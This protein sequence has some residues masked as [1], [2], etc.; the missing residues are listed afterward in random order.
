MIQGVGDVGSLADHDGD[1]ECVRV[2]ESRRGNQEPVMRQLCVFSDHD[3]LV[4]GLPNIPSPT[5]GSLG[6]YV[7]KN[8]THSL[9]WNWWEWDERY[10]GGASDIRL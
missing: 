9:G 8:S 3:E 5:S 7:S 10:R 2:S 4:V 6:N 1:C